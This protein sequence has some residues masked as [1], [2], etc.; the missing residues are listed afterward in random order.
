MPQVT[1]RAL[2]SLTGDNLVNTKGNQVIKLLQESER[3]V[4]SA[5]DEV[6]DQC[7]DYRQDMPK[8]LMP[9]EDEKIKTSSYVPKNIATGNNVKKNKKKKKFGM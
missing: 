2:K 4:T 9:D 3:F 8:A 1:G 5:M 7:I 6:I